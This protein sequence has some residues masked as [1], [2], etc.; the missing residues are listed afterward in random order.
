VFADN[1]LVRVG[2]NSFARYDNVA[3]LGLNVIHPA[4]IFIRVTAS[5]VSQRFT[6]TPL[7]DLPRSNFALL[8]LNATYEFAGKRGLANLRISNAFDRRFA[9]IIEGLTI[10]AF[11]P[12][13]RAF[14]SLRWRLW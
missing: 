9:S 11:I 14:A 10:D 2:A 7:T 13:R 1:Q 3:R 6:E 12:D 4:G 8:D 5:H